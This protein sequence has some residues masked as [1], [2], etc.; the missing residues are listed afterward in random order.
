MAT[1]DKPKRK[2]SDREIRAYMRD[3]TEAKDIRDCASS[4]H[5]TISGF[6]RFLFQE[7]KR[8]ED[9]KAK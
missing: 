2:Y 5:R 8:L 6:V 9:N 4:S 7:W 3:A 1:S